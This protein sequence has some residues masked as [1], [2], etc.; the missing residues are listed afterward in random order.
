MPTV[1]DYR[2]VDAGSITVSGGAVHNY[3]AFNLPLAD[4]TK[5][6]ILQFQLNPDT[7]AGVEVSLNGNVVF[8]R[9]SFGNP[10]LRTL[11][12]AVGGGVLVNNGNAI[13]VTNTGSVDFD[14][15]DLILWFQRPN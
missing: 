11:A 7:G 6:A 1:A 2:I 4:T 8:A 9:P 15:S 10:V 12:E 14:L 13:T 3:P 5:E